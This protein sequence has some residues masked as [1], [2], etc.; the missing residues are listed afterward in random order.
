MYFYH[1]RWGNHDW[2]ISAVSEGGAKEEAGRMA[3]RICFQLGNV[4]HDEEP[5]LIQVLGKIAA[6]VHSINLTQTGVAC[7]EY[8]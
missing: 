4:E 6:S 3:N 7:K 1:F 5:K 8:P 2:I